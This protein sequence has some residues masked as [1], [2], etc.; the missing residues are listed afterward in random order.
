MKIVFEYG[1]KNFLN[2]K[3]PSLITVQQS[4]D[5][6]KLFTVTYGLQVETDLTYLQ[7]CSEI[8]QCLLYYLVCESIVDNSGL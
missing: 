2:P 7:A 8:G 5:R 3:V 4:E 6:D 1:G